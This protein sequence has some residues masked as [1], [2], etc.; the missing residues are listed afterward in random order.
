MMYWM[1]N[2]PLST[3]HHACD[4]KVRKAEERKG[5]AKAFDKAGEWE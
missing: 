2:C 3:D 5:E 1:S 4:D